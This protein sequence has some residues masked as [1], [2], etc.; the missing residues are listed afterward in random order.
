MN[1]VTIMA[2]YTNTGRYTRHLFCTTADLGTDE[3]TAELNG[4]F[5]AI[6][7]QIGIDDTQHNYCVASEKQ[8]EMAQA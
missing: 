5:V 2:I 1:E 4:T 8:V 3:G 6:C 7:G